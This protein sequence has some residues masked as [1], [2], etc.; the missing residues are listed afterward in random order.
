[1]ADILNRSFCLFLKICITF[2]LNAQKVSIVDVA[3]YPYDTILKGGYTISYRVDDSVQYLY[4]NK[5]NKTISEL[6]S[7]SR[8]MPYKNLGYVVADFTNFF[9]LAHSFGSGNPHYIELIKK[10]T[11][12]NTLN[13][14]AI[15]IDAEENKE[16]LL[17]CNISDLEKNG[18]MTLFNLRTGRKQFFRFPGDILNGT[19]VLNRIRIS[20]LTEKQ[21]VIR[22]EIEHATKIKLYNR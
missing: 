15:W 12:E 8:G 9:V 16:Y 2:S 20:R 21:L 19:E 7:T 5:D 3:S 11:G 10:R 13:S 17:Y 14:E 4:L 1:M 22:Y 6:F 18:K